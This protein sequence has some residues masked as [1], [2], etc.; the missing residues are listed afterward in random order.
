MWQNCDTCHKI[1]KYV[2]VAIT[3]LYNTIESS[4]SIIL[5]HTIY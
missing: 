3:Q 4:G 1:V 2:T 5:Y